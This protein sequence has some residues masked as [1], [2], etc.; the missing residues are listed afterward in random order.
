MH[1]LRLRLGRME[2]HLTHISVV[3]SGS[4]QDLFYYRIF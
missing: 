3:D 1:D 2:L 4:S